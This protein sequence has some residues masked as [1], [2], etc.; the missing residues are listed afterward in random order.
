MCTIIALRGVHPAYPLIVAA[1]RDEFTRRV[2][3]PPTALSTS[4]LVVGGRDRQAL[5][6]WLAV[7]PRGFFVALTNQRTWGMPDRSRR[8]RGELV[9][10]AARRG[11]VDAVGAYLRA[12]PARRYNPFNLLFGDATSLAAAYVRDD[13]PTVT[14]EPLGPGMHVLANDSIG[15]PWFP[16][17]ARPGERVALGAVAAMGLD[18]VLAAL[19]GALGDHTIPAEIPPPPAGSLMPAALA[20]QLQAMCVHTPGYGTVSATLF[21]ATAEGAA[22]YLYADGPPC[23][24]GFV[25]YTGLLR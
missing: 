13:D 21:V 15:S 1:N 10:E 12:Q 11:S 7:T 4:P 9:I 16:K 18:E 3:T 2:A 6:T 8:S 20:R 14:V 24:T 5:G 17:V 22:R 19:V 25:E 23:V